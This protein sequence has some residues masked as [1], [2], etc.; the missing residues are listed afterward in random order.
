MANIERGQE[1]AVLYQEIKH[2]R[3]WPVYLFHGDEEFLISK[4]LEAVQRSVLKGIPVDFNFDQYYGRES[5]TQRIVESANTLPMMAPRRLVILKDAHE[6][7]EAGLERLVKYCEK[8]SPT[9]VF[10][11]V[12]NAMGQKKKLIAA[13]KKNGLVLEL[14]QL[15]EKQLRPWIK[16]EVAELGKSIGEDGVDFLIDMVGDSLRELHSE[17][18]KVSLY[19]GKRER[20]TMED[21]HAVVSDVSLDTIFE[22]THAVGARD[23]GKALMQLTKMLENDPDASPIQIVAMLH[24]HF[25]QLYRTRMLLNE[26]LPNQEI[27]R[28]AGVRENMVWKWEKEVLPQAKKRQRPELVKALKLLY[29]TNLSL[30]SSRVPPGFQLEALVMRLCA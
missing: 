4:A 12:G 3:L 25:Q 30:R 22:F 10:V 5:E 15:Y 14:R 28:Q 26:G 7:K 13:V 23:A 9:T 27:A 29:Q 18:L 2:G 17:I 16:G 8:P 19:A 20:I 24:R 11:M 1:L 6:I 21:L